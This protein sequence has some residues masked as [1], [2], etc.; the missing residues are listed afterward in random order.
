MEKI[1]REQNV[2]QSQ[3]EGGEQELPPIPLEYEGD[4]LTT[5]HQHNDEPSKS[6]SSM[7]HNDMYDPP[8]NNT[9]EINSFY[10][11]ASVQKLTST[12]IRC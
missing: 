9:V 10:P 7:T 4:K 8:D 3:P 11:N 6:K 12:V 5:P 2:V 1:K